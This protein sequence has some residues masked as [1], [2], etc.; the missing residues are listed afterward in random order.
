MRVCGVELRS[1]E[2][3]ITLLSEDNGLFD[4]PDCRTRRMVLNDLNSSEELIEFNK[5]FAKLVEDYKI[6]KVVIKA[7]PLKG[8][9]AGSAAGFKMEAAIQMIGNADVHII[10][11]SAVK[12]QLKHTPLMIDFR[13]TGLKKFQEPAFVTAFAWLSNKQK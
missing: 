2:A 13:D 12:E 10:S 3:I 11:S 5:T 1:N 6:D 9:F 7:R 4:I 8:K